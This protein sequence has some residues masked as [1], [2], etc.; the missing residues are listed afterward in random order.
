MAHLHLDQMRCV[1]GLFLI[2][3]ARMDTGRPPAAEQELHRDRG[4][5]DDQGRS[6]CSRNA[7]MMDARVATGRSLDSRAR[8][9]AGAGRR[10]VRSSS[11]SK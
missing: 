8:I 10:L 5:E 3:E 6:L 9:S 7:E 2:C 4:V 1:P 11:A